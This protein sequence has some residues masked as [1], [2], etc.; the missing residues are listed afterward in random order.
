MTRR[1]FPSLSEEELCS[2]ESDGNSFFIGFT[3]TGSFSAEFRLYVDNECYYA[4]QTSP[5]NRT[6]YLADRAQRFPVGTKISLRL[7]HDSTQ[8]E[9]FVGTI[10]GGTY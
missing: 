9:T 10:L 6:A 2:W 3:A 4:Y 7:F 5:G 8:Q 1:S